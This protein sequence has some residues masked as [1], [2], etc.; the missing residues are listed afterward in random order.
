MKCEFLLSLQGQLL[1]DNAKVVFV[2][3]IPSRDPYY[4]GIYDL[5][6]KG[7]RMKEKK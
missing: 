4:P 5:K 7:K 6:L 3:N 1:R 2:I